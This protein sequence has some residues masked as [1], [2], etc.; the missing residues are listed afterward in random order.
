MFSQFIHLTQKAT[1]ENDYHVKDIEIFSP[2]SESILHIYAWGEQITAVK[3]FA[4]IVY[5]IRN[6]LESVKT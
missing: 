5:F 6:D 4:L 3:P 2:N 1:T